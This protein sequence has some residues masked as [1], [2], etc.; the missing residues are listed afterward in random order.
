MNTLKEDSMQDRVNKI[1]EETRESD[2]HITPYIR[3]AS[4]KYPVLKWS[5]ISRFIKYAWSFYAPGKLMGHFFNNTLTEEEIINA[6]LTLLN[7]LEKYNHTWGDGDSCDRE[8]LA[9][10]IRSTRGH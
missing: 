7:N 10:V 6:T 9:V 2:K 1:I 3:E 4:K 8:K 5:K